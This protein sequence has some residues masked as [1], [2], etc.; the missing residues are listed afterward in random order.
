MMTDSQKRLKVL[1][2]SEAA[3]P[4]W[5]SVPLVGW[6][7]SMAISQLVQG[8]LVTQV[9]N[10]DAIV[11]AGL[12]EGPDFTAIDSER[13]A[14]TMWRV[15]SM[16]RGGS[17]K[18]WTTLAAFAPISYYYFE[19]LVWRKF[20]PAIRRGEY[21]VV[22]RITP[23][24][25]TTPS[26]LAKQCRRHGVPFLLGPLNGGVPWPKW[27]EAERKREKEWLVPVRKAYR[28]LPGSRA[29]LRDSAAIIA[30]SRHTQMEIPAR[31]QH[32]VHY[33]PENAIDPNRFPETVQTR[34]Y[35]KPLKLLFVGR[36][37]PYK[38][39]DMVIEA[40]REL[41]HSGQAMLTIVGDGPER[42]R[43]E[44][45]AG[46]LNNPAAVTFIGE[47]PH[48]EVQRHFSQADVFAFP[49][50]REFGGAVVLE[51][52]T[53][54]CVPVIVNYGGPAELITPD[55][56]FT[57]EVGPRESI[58][59]DLKARLTEI[60]AQPH[61]LAQMSAA[62]RRHVHQDY[63]WPAKAAQVYEVYQQIL[64][65]PSVAACV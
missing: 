31:Y 7:H 28:L 50:I 15:A 34:T 30:G 29:T 37:V 49:S 60:A 18:G 3:N 63:S 39:C 51:A 53:M 62:G 6:S 16:F 54:G 52:M 23:L 47:V 25:P 17:G 13:V 48:A 58:I 10:R 27:F 22:H 19:H 9:R 45:L 36:L 46:K 21:D 43:L 4:E 59:R 44:A 11:R 12:V 14:K 1:L 41:L 38:G 35:E 42:S 40:A 8:H 32:K 57:L 33:I 55:C 20:G 26:I 64:T 56:A 24:S 61:C 2:I 65:R 5:T